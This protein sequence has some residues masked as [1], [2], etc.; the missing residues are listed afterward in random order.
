[1]IGGKENSQET[2]LIKPGIRHKKAV[3]FRMSGT[4]IFISV[5]FAVRGTVE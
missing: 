5:D 4:A 3:S 2:E 1:M